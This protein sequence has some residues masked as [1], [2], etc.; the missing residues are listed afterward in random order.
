MA[1]MVPAIA[2]RARVDCKGCGASF[3]VNGLEHA[4]RCPKCRQPRKIDWKTVLKEHLARYER[5]PQKTHES[6]GGPNFVW[7]HVDL[8]KRTLACECK[9][10]VEAAEI[11]AAL[12]SKTF[13]CPCG[14]KWPVRPRAPADETKL[15]ARVRG[16]FG[17]VAPAAPVA[18][19]PRPAGVVD[20]RCNHCGAPISFGGGRSA[21]CAYCKT[22][23]LLQ[24]AVEAE[25]QAATPQ[26]WFV[27]L[28]G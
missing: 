7:Q 17:E 3:P 11:D 4:P 9:R 15:D 26:I 18:R 2:V 14:K 23:N 5:I 20:V 24:E 12:A 8:W 10:A 16:F 27:V 22:E 25:P 28:S 13:A 6:A 19:K 1:G 21:T